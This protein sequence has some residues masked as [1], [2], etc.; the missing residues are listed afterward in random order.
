MTEPDDVQEQNPD[1]A[2]E[3]DPP[4]TQETDA[5]DDDLDLDLDTDQGGADSV[6]DPDLELEEV[7]FKGVKGQVPRGW[8]DNWQREL[9]SQQQQTAADRRQLEDRQREIEAARQA[10]DDDL[11]DRGLVRHLQKVLK[12]YEDLTPEQRARI[13]EEDLPRALELQEN[14]AL[15]RRDIDAAK[16]RIADRKT[17]R[18]QKAEAEASQRLQRFGSRLLELEPTWKPETSQQVS[19]YGISAGIP[20]EKLSAASAEE[21]VILRKA[22][23]YDQARARQARARQAEEAPTPTSKPPRGRSAA[24]TSQPSDSDSMAEWVRKETA[25]VNA[26]RQAG[27]KAI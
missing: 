16:Q 20:H 11:E 14:E 22:M 8:K 4:V 6:V 21:A 13:R 7:E 2:P 18:G 1:P 17:E 9:T 24:A 19:Q 3:N 15:I 23:L 5:D 27:L 10:D 25:R 12:D 26:K